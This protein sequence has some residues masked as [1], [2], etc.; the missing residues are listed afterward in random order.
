LNLRSLKP[1]TPPA[2]AALLILL[3][4]LAYLPAIGAGYIWDDDT[5]LTAN[6]QMRSIQGLGEIWRGEHSRDYTP[7]TLTSFWA[8]WRLWGNNPTGYHVVNILLHA[9][10]AVLVWLILGRLRV[11]G[12]WLG[13]LLFAIHPVNV[14]SV[15]WIA[16]R[17]NTLS[18][19]FFFGALLLFLGYREGRDGKR[20]AAYVGSLGL[21]VLAALSKGAVVTLPAVLLLCVWWKDRKVTRRD[22]IAVIPYAVIAI[23]AALLTIRFQARAQH[24]G[25]L[26][27]SLDYRVARAGAA[28]WF[29][30]GALIWPGG[31]SPMRAPWLPNLRSPLTYLPA[32]V[33]A[34]AWALFFRKRGSW[35]RPLLFAYTYYLIMLLPVLGFVWMTLM[36]ETPSADWWQYTAAPGIFAC[37]AAGA[38]TAGGRWRM[39]MPLAC[40]GIALLLI[41]TWRRAAIYESMES[42]CVAVTAEDPHAWTLEN[43]LGIMLKRRGRFAESAACYR[44]ALRDNPGY[45]EAHV[46]LGNTLGASGD[47]AGEEAEFRRADQM[48][49]GDPDLLE[50]LANLYAAEGRTDE[51]LASEAEAVKAEPGSVARLARFGVMLAANG[52]FAEAEGC[53]RQAV[54]IAPNFLLVR[55]E[56]C[57]AL[58][59]E[60]KK[61]PALDQC[62]VIENL[63]R[64]NGDADALRAAADLRRECGL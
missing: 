22:L 58:I 34:G 13:A 37:V 20:V 49:P 61:A 38:V 3:T 64:K 56:L 53:F 26:P 25:L 12:A 42:Y 39:V 6:P 57:Q 59:H 46:N 23:A 60:G 52:R 51:A 31:M 1:L 30:L 2:L 41:Q 47:P 36:Q 62:G 5:L 15:A 14:A 4:V 50:D 27:D 40:I 54:E 8:E 44:Q 55:I 18:A 16:E 24:Y 9:L 21:F 33:A 29:Y 7:V 45:V 43:N 35:G 11:P 10:S 19:A 63:A 48:R 17:K 32:L 28:I